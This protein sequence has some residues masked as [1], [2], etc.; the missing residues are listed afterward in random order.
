MN[1]LQIIDW[2]DKAKTL[3]RAVDHQKSVVNI[4]PSL[5]ILA[6]AFKQNIARKKLN[7]F[8]GLKR[9]NL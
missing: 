4:P 9:I 2:E 3:S 6:K 7:W 5:R 8:D 1:A